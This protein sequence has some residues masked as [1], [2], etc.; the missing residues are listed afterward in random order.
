MLSK[1]ILQQFIAENIPGYKIY[2]VSGDSD[3]LCMISSLSISLSHVLKRHVTNK[4]VENVIR[5]EAFENQGFY[6][7][8]APGVNILEELENFLKNPLKFY[9]EDTCDLFL[10]MCG[11]GFNANTVIFQSDEEKAWIVNLAPNDKEHSTTLYF[12]RS[13]SLHVDPVLPINFVMPSLDISHSEDA[14][15]GIEG[16]TDDTDRGKYN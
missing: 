13:V 15:L 9:G 5:K 1:E 11:N 8:F 3:G 6:V 10:M 4:D 16:L 7:D 2:P 12:G 14:I